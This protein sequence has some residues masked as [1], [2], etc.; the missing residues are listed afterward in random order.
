MNIDRE[1]WKIIYF[2]K[3]RF[4]GVILL[5]KD[6]LIIT[7]D[8]KDELDNT[9][10]IKYWA[11][12]PINNTYSFSNRGKPFH[13]KDQAYT[14]KVN[15]GKSKITN[16][17]FTC[18]ITMPNSY[19]INLGTDLIKPILNIQMD[20]DNKYDFIQLSDGIPFRSL[21]LPSNHKESFTNVT[22]PE[23]RSQSEILSDSA[24]P[25]KNKNQENFWGFKPP[26]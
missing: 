5:N 11:A 1:D 16:N 21:S 8:V 18:S 24:F 19:Y 6:K 9:Q 13:N 4:K 2:D 20:G 17:R 25:A 26:L 12:D 10:Y 7:G 23:D 14:K 15:I 22:L 3:D